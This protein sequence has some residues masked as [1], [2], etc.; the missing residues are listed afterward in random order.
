MKAYRVFLFDNRVLFLAVFLFFLMFGSQ[1]HCEA[2]MYQADAYSKMSIGA[3]NGSPSAKRSDNFSNGVNEFVDLFTGQHTERFPLAAIPGRNGLSVSVELSYNGNVGRIVNSYNRNIQAP[4]VGLGFDLGLESIQ[5]NDMGTPQLYDDKYYLIIGRQR[6]AL[7]PTDNGYITED[8]NPWTI[9]RHVIQHEGQDFI[10]GWKI[11]REDGTEYTYGDFNNGSSDRNA[12]R[13]ILRWGNSFSPG[14]TIDAVLY[15]YQWDLCKVEDCDGLNSIDFTYSQEIDYVW[16]YNNGNPANTTRGYTR[17][18]YPALIT[19]PGGYQIRFDKSN[20]QDFERYQTDN[21]VQIYQT[22]KINA[23]VVLDSDGNEVSR[24][25]LQYSYLNSTE[26]ANV[27]KLLLTDIIHQSANGASNLSATHFDY[28]DQT[29]DLNFGAIKSVTSPS[30]GLREIDYKIIENDSNFAVLHSE[31]GGNFVTPQFSISDGFYAIDMRGM[32]NMSYLYDDDEKA[33]GAW[34]GYWINNVEPDYIAQVRDK[35]ASSSDGWVAHFDNQYD[36]IIVNRWMDGYWK[37]EA[38]DMS[39]QPIAGGVSCDAVNLYAGNDFLL[40][41]DASEYYWGLDWAYHIYLYKWNGSE[42]IEK[43]ILNRDQ[44]NEI[45]VIRDINLSTDMVMLHCFRP[46][47]HEFVKC[48]K[49]LPETESIVITNSAEIDKAHLRDNYCHY[50][51][52]RTNHIVEWNG[53]S[54]VSRTPTDGFPEAQNVGPTNFGV[55][56]DQVIR[57]YANWSWTT[58]HYRYSIGR[59][60]SGWN[61]TAQDYIMTTNGNVYEYYDKVMSSQNLVVT[62]KERNSGSDSLHIWNFNGGEWHST[63]FRI[64]DDNATVKVLDNIVACLSNDTLYVKK[65]LGQGVWGPTEALVTDAYTGND[66]DGYLREWCFSIQ[67]NYVVIKGTDW[68]RHARVFKWVNNNWFEIVDFDDTLEP[69][70]NGARDFSTITTPGSFVIS[71]EC[72]QGTYDYQTIEKQYCYKWYN[73]QCYGKAQYPVVSHIK[74]LENAADQNPII[75]EISYYGGILDKSGTTPRF[76][77]TRISTPYFPGDDPDGYS[78][79]YFYNDIDNTGFPNAAIYNEMEFPDLESTSRYNVSNGGYRLDGLEYL[80]YSYSPNDL[81]SAQIDST[82]NYYSLQEA[83]TDGSNVYRLIIDSIHTRR[84][85][86]PQD[87]YFLY[88]AE[89]GQVVEEKSVIRNGGDSKWTKKET[90]YAFQEEDV[91]G[92]PT[93]TAIAM[94]TDNAL[95]YILDTKTTDY[96]GNTLEY[97]GSHYDSQGSWKKSETFTWRDFDNLQDTL[98]MNVTVAY[99]EYGNVIENTDAQGVNVAVKYS[100]NGLRVVGTGVNCSV[101]DYFVLDFEQEPTWDGWVSLTTNDFRWIDNTDAF[102]GEHCFKIIDQ[103]NQNHNWGG[104]RDFL[105]EDLTSDKY[106][107]SCWV[108]A[109][110]EIRF[111]FFCYDINGN[112]VSTGNPDK[113]FDFENVSSTEWEKV[114]GVIDFSDLDPNECYRIRATWVLPQLA[115]MPPDP[116]GK[117]DNFRFHPLNAHVTTSVYDQVSGKVISDIDRNNIP[118]RYEYDEFNRLV[119]EYDY[120]GNA[121]LKKSYGLST[122]DNDYVKNITYRTIDEAPYIDSTIVVSYY[123]GLGRHL[124]TRTSNYIDNGSGVQ[125]EAALVSGVKTYD[126]RGRVIREYKPYFDLDEPAGVED[127]STMTFGYYGDNTVGHEVNTYYNG[128]NAVDCQYYPYTENRYFNDYDG[129]IM[130]ESS[131]GQTYA[132]GYNH[133]TTYSYNEYENSMVEYVYDPDDNIKVVSSN[134]YNFETYEVATYTDPYGSK[135]QIKRT[136]RDI[137]GKVDSVSVYDNTPIPIMR[138]WYNDLGQK[139]STWRVDYGKIRMY[140]DNVGNLRF[141]QNDMRENEGT[142]V[143]FKYDLFGRKIEEGVVDEVITSDNMF[144]QDSANSRD[145]PAGNIPSANIDRSYYWNYDYLPEMGN[146][147]EYGNLLSTGKN[148]N[149]YYRKYHYYPLENKDSVTVKLKITGGDIKSI[150]HEYDRLSGDIRKLTVYPGETA[151]GSRAYD[152][153]YDRSGRLHTIDEGTYDNSPMGYSRSYVGFEYNAH[154]QLS[155][156]LLGIYEAGSDP[157]TVQVIDYSYNTVG[158]LARINDPA[159]VVAQA[160]GIGGDNDHFGLFLNEANYG[161]RRYNGLVFSSKAVNSSAEGLRTQEYHYLYNE[162]G[163]LTYANSVTNNGEDR[164]YWYNYLGNR[165]SIQTGLSTKYRYNYDDTPGSS[166]FLG[167]GAAISRT[168]DALG[169]LTTDASNDI[170]QQ[171]YDYR[172]QLTYA[173]V[174]EKYFG[175]DPQEL[176]FG[177]DEN[178]QRIYKRFHYCYKAPCDPPIPDDPFEMMPEEGDKSTTPEKPNVPVDGKSIESETVTKAFITYCPYWANMEEHY[179]YDGNV[180]LMIFDKNDNVTQSYVNSFM[181]KEAVHKDNNDNSRYYILSDQVGSAR[182]LL[183]DAGTVVQW[184]TYLPFGGIANGWQNYDDPMKY[185]GKQKDKHST[186][187]NYYFGMRYYDPITGHFTSIDKAFQF[188]SGYNYCG[189]NPISNMDPD[190]NFFW[191]ALFYINYYIA[192]GQSHGNHGYAFKYAT[193]NTATAYLSGQVLSFTGSE[194]AAR[195]FNNS[196]NNIRNGGA[197]ILDLGIYTYEVGGHG[198]WIDFEGGFGDISS[199]I[200]GCAAFLSD[201]SKYQNWL[202][203][204][205]NPKPKNPRR[206]D[207]PYTD[208]ETLEGGEPLYGWNHEQLDAAAVNWNRGYHIADPFSYLNFITTKVFGFN[209]IKTFSTWKKAQGVDHEG[210]SQRYGPTHV[211]QN[212]PGGNFFIHNEFGVANVF[213]FGMFG[214]WI[215]IRPWGLAGLKVF[216]LAHDYQYAF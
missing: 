106:Y 184:T 149:S 82:L 213:P 47:E 81:P 172:N 43:K 85:G 111:Q 8:G 194:L 92:N 35:P 201:Y 157:D 126:S 32:Y 182:V 118:T 196:V 204:N 90:R 26:N 197:P 55:F 148:D 113:R 88:D 128:T 117:F 37:T 147:V 140:Y 57:E 70:E 38:I 20:R 79:H 99:D 80:S 41:I 112:L 50:R 31:V 115:S 78:V 34:N 179:L 102:T 87:T 139:D 28:Y 178:S 186:F 86:T 136:N 159:T 141:L 65:H 120:A 67:D 200:F 101:K 18:S 211:T 94:Q 129:R 154:G 107:F 123:D 134:L 198:Q 125:V 77:R 36:N 100:D 2:E 127:F 63:F 208:T 138:Y 169:N 192:F 72:Y 75:T 175:G 153:S 146:T 59:G 46:D 69:P 144:C 58:D 110:S 49:Y 151:I 10:Q 39:W 168:Y 76:A 14:S 27:R 206:S 23:V 60:T 91:Y 199:D 104:R 119:G 22:Q 180:L 11:V 15:P 116:W 167:Y 97:T 108:K 161:N 17:A 166:R 29:G 133:T 30:G 52:N 181:G 142:F 71:W 152:Y 40:V 95:S 121:I 155:Q 19:T 48:V 193:I 187:D 170:Y 68:H 122:S 185:T 207:E 53:T 124:Q 7:V 160:T 12:T 105:F 89:T 216:Y 3:A 188:P 33:Y 73:N 74:L 203:D 5:T 205:G 61:K 212:K 83:A 109:S 93:S 214:H 42:W 165:D 145:F 9:T 177:Y 137:S 4:I 96:E 54:W 202:Y 51:N 130:E 215:E 183:D 21:F 114:E 189:N 66:N 131:P 13:Y 156:K 191:Y 62:L 103:D 195:T 163:W 6:L 164:K 135:M 45:F 24:T 25:A 150:V 16:T 176:Y 84:D 174:K 162:L 132:I 1:H 98:Y 173:A 56:Y 143:Y 64:V 158:G 44:D 209:Y 190:G 171:N 210:Y